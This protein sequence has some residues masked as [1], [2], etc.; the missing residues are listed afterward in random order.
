MTTE[1]WHEKTFGGENHYFG[2]DDSFMDVSKTHQNINFKHVKF[3]VV[4]LYL[5]KVKRLYLNKVMS[6]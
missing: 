6:S 4:Q 1:N 3:I 2:C 5:N